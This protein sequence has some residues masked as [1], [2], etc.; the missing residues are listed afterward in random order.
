MLEVNGTLIVLILSFLLFVWALNQVFVKPVAK[1]LAAR[2]AKIEQD[3]SASR[4]L[5][6]EAEGVLVQY[7]KRL[8]EVRT[9]AQN[10]INDAVVEAQKKRSEEMAAV[11]AEGRKRVDTARTALA[12]EKKNLVSELVDSEILIVDTIMKKLIGN[13]SGGALERGTVQKALEE[14]C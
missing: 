5:R 12:Q 3:L 7:E 9:R 8:A 10:T 2:S 14:A 4:K 11:Q 1:T 13:A 6:E